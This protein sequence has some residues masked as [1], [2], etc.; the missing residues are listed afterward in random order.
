MSKNTGARGLRTIL[1]NILMDAMYEIPDAKSGEKRIDAV[2]VD[3]DAVG[4]V[5]RPGSGAKILYGD[6]ALDRYLSE[7]KA[8]G[9]G[10]GSEVDGEAELSSSRAIGM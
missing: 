1:E 7:M 10:A 4:S 5:D 6:G 3:E 8:S 2:V 9:D